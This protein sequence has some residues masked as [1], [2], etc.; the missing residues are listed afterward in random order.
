MVMRNFSVLQQ[1]QEEIKLDIR[2]SGGRGGIK[3]M[4][5]H[6]LLQSFVKP[7]WNLL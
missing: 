1:R 4:L 5:G 7:F 6:G 2:I 3:S